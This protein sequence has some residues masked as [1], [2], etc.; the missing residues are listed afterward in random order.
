[1]KNKLLF[2]LFVLI[3]FSFKNSFA[4]QFK[5]FG[6]FQH[7]ANQWVYIEYLNDNLIKQTDSAFATDG[8]FFFKGMVAEPTMGVVGTHDEKMQNNF[9]FEP[10][11]T[12]IIADTTF[13]DNLIAT[14]GSSTAQY[15]NYYTSE[16]PRRQQRDS[17]Y[18]VISALQKQGDTTAVK[19]QWKDFEQL[20]T[21]HKVE[22]E[23]WMT[24]HTNWV[25]NAYL[26]YG[27]YAHPETMAKGDSLLVLMA[28]NVQASKYVRKR[29]Q[30]K[31]Q[32]EK[33]AIGK[34]VTHFTQ[35]DTSGKSVST[36]NFAGKYFLIDFWAS[37]C[38]PCRRENPE[39][40]KAYQ[41]FHP[42]GFEIIGVSLDDDKAKWIKAIAKDNLT[43]TH[44][45]DLKGWENAAAALYAV[46]SIPDNFLIDKEGKIIAKSLRGEELSAKLE[47][48][49]GK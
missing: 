28:A 4:Q 24:A 17:M 37:W 7:I 38:G 40:V 41:K 15:S 12:Y 22:E 44:V 21:H 14:G 2:L 16:E 10:G 9:F 23:A 27:M 31:Q 3:A 42:K 5:I 29:E 32:L 6:N 25:V 36:K 39:V 13:P 19:N 35:N 43:W 48:I 45:S 20:Y 18:K 8:K 34:L 49:L 1:M 11:T 30:I 46:R 26:I 33:S 47:E